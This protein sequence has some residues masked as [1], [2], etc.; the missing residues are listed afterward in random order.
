MLLD[1]PEDLYAAVAKAAASIRARGHDEMTPERVAAVLIR[2]GLGAAAAEAL[3]S[4]VVLDR[5]GAQVVEL[6]VRGAF[7]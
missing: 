5:L 1:L 7:R 6:F 4:P 3:D 2:I